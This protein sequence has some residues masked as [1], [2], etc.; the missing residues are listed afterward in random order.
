MWWQGEA[1]IGQQTGLTVSVVCGLPCWIGG[2]CAESYVSAARGCVAGLA[3]WQAVVVCTVAVQRIEVITGAGGRR[4]YSAEEKIRLVGEARGGRGAVAAVARRHG[5]C[6]SLIYRWRR[7]IRSGEL[8]PEAASF[9]PVHLVVA[10][11]VSEGEPEFCAC[12]GQAEEG[13]AALAAC[14]AAG[15]AADLALGDLAA[16]VVFRAV[17]VKRDIGL[18]EDHQQFRLVGVEA[19]EQPVEGGEAGLAFED[20]VEAGTQGGLSR[21]RRIVAIGL[22]VGVEPPDQAA[23]A[24]LGG[25]MMIGEG[26]ELVDQ[27]LGMDPAQGMAPDVELSSVVADDDGVGQQILR[28]DIQ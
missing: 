19:G 12:L 8:S 27:A 2:C 3:S 10:E 11:I 14:V 22:E 17:G 7:Q 26:V 4:A 28:P 21:R 5:V 20:A 13:V 24:L 1:R 6:S 15:A 9:V 23:D 18:V 16:D 25:A